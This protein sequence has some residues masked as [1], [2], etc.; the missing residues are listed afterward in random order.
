[1]IVYTSTDDD[2]FT[3]QAEIPVDQEPKLLFARSQMIFSLTPFRE[4]TGYL[5]ETGEMPL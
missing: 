4:I 2:G 5:S 1:M 3:Y